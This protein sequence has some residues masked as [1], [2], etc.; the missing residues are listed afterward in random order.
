MALTGRRPR[1]SPETVP[2][3]DGS[4]GFGPP[5]RDPR[6]PPTSPGDGHRGSILEAVAL[7]A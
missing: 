1:A 6:P 4:L 3:G 7:A 5:A 2:G